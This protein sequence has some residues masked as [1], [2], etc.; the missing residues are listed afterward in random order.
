MLSHVGELFLQELLQGWKHNPITWITFALRK[1]K[2]G[3]R[4]TLVNM[5]HKK[6]GNVHVLG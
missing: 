6:L 4:V 3:T 1:G 5:K 2:H